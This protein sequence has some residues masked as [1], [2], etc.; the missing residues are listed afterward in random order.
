V[1]YLPG[2][3]SGEWR[4]FTSEGYQGANPEWAPPAPYGNIV[5]SLDWN[6]EP[7]GM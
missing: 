2:Y 6:S 5:F 4:T 7:T 1:P 3:T